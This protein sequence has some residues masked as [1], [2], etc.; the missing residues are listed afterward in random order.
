MFC[1][2]WGRLGL[3]SGHPERKR[4]PGGQGLQGGNLNPQLQR[5]LLNWWNL[6]QVS[7]QSPQRTAVKDGTNFL[8]PRTA[9]DSCPGY[10]SPSSLNPERWD[11]GFS[12]TDETPESKR[13]RR[14]QEGTRCRWRQGK[15]ST[16]VTETMKSRND[17]S[18]Q[19][20]T[21]TAQTRHRK[22]PEPGCSEKKGCECCFV[23]TGLGLVGQGEA[24]GTRVLGF[25]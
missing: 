1:K 21:D 5:D 16:Q 11:Q 13:R 24:Q 14:S 10:S 19:T 6:E 4:R 3:C 12:G 22:G 7:S 2:G 18:Q 23:N 20:H 25:S 17:H 8:S 15:G 9:G